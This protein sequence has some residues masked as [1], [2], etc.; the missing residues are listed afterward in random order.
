MEQP[1]SKLLNLGCGGQW[2]PAWVNV[3]MA[4]ADPSVLAHNLQNPLPFPSES[5]TAVYHSHVLE[6]LPRYRALPFLQECHR[7]LVNV[8]IIRVVVPDLETLAV[9]YLENLRGSLKADKICQERYEWIV[10]ELLDQMVRQQADG[11]EMFKYLCQD[12]IPAWDF[13]V[14]RFG[15]EVTS[16]LPQIKNYVKMGTNP[17]TIDQNRPPLTR[18]KVGEYRLSGEVH[19]WMYDRYSLKRLLDAAGFIEAKVVAATESNIPKFQDFNLDIVNGAV[20]KPD[21]LFIEARK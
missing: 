17:K 15:S 10:I 11:G 4:P 14:Q 7:V 1:S 20:R 9:L 18:G 12:P 16:K 19:Q 3:D 21:S 13:V 8:G 5:F 2:H 6:H